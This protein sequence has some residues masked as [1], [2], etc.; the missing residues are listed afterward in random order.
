MTPED[1][2]LDS[3]FDEASAQLHEGLKTCR[4]VVRNYRLMLGG[5]QLGQTDQDGGFE[6]SAANDA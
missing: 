3:D 2:P 1:H 5:E 6:D 4:T